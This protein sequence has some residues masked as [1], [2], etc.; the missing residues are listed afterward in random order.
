M[1]GPIITRFQEIAQGGGIQA[2]PSQLAKL[3][4]LKLMFWGNQG[5]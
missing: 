2:E 4:R 5:I 1:T 3:W